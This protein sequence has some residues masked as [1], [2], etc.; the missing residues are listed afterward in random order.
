MYTK[1]VGADIVKLTKMFK[2]T[3]ASIG[4]NG[5]FIIEV[6]ADDIRFV[7]AYGNTLAQAISQIKKL[8]SEKRR[9][10]KRVNSET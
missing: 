8:L 1:I 2:A 10:I 3:R 7:Y 4:Y 6:W 5:E 9:A